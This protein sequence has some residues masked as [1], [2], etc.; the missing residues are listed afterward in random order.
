M[1]F[2]VTCLAAL[3]DH[4]HVRPVVSLPTPRD[5]IIGHLEVKADEMWSFVKQKANKQWIWSAMDKQTCQII[6]LHVGGRSHDSAKH[7]SAALPL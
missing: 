7:R 5:V 3:P 6:T 2:I 1:H 4:L